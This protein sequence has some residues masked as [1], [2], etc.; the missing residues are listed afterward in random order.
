VFKN[1]RSPKRLRK[2]PAQRIVRR[3]LKTDEELPM[4]F[5]KVVAVLECGHRKTYGFT[6]CPA[7]YVLCQECLKE[8][9]RR[10]KIRNAMLDQDGYFACNRC[11]GVRPKQYARPCM[12]CGDRI[13]EACYLVC[14][15]CN[16]S[17]CIECVVSHWFRC[18]G[19]DDNG[20]LQAE[21]M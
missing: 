6:K 9:K 18:N 7:E 1:R 16:R 3:E 8:E 17:V 13:C 20:E 12:D 14:N 15:E 5:W 2:G 11:D 19:G 21:G 10:R 4:R